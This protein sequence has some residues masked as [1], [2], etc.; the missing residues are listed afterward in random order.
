MTKTIRKNVFILM[1]AA[2]CLSGSVRAEITP[3]RHD[4]NVSQQRGKVTGTVTDNLGPVTGASVFV[5][6][7]TNGTVTDANGQF[8]LEGVQN[9]AIIQ[10]SFLG[11][12][13][14]EIPFTGQ[15]T[16]SVVLKEDTQILDEVVVV[17]YGSVK[18]AS[19]TGAVDQVKGSTLENRPIVSVGHALQGVVANLNITSS[20]SQNE[21]GGGA[22]GAKMNFNI[23]GTTGLNGDAASASA[24]P[25]IVIDG[26]Q[27]GDINSVNPD[28]IESISV[29]KDA[30][31]AAIYGSSAPYGVVLITTKQG[32]RERKPV[33]SYSNNFAMASVINLP[34]MM[35]SVDWAE[36]TNEA[37]INSI[38]TPFI[39]D[40]AMQRI[41]DYAAGKISTT[42]II[43]PAGN[44]VNQWAAYDP[45]FGN[46]NID[47]LR[48]YYKDYAFSQQHNASVSGGTEKTTYYVGLGYNHRGGMYNFGS[49]SFDRY[50]FRGNLSSSITKWL[51]ANFRSAFTRGYTD[52]PSSEHADSGGIMHDLARLWPIIP[53]KN[54]DGTVNRN[55]YID[56]YEN[57][58]RINNTDDRTVLTG[59]FVLNPLK[60]WNATFNYTFDHNSVLKEKN[61]LVPPNT[62]DA[63]GNTI[64]GQSREPNYDVLRRESGNY[65]HHTIN[66]FTSYELGLNDHYLKG[67]I[68]YT[69]EQRINRWFMA[70]SSTGHLYTPTV[71]TFPTIYDDTKSASEDRSTT[72]S[73]G[74]FGRINYGYKDKYLLEV[75]ARYDGTSRFLK[76]VRW[77]TY[78]GVSAAWVISKESFWEPVSDIANL[79]KLRFSYGSLGD[80]SFL[81]SSNF[82]YPLYY[83]PFSP[84]MGTTAPTGSNNNWIFGS[85]GRGSYITSPAIINEALTW[86]TST[87]FDIGVDLAA[88]DNRLSVTYDWF[89]RNSNDIVGPAEQLPAVLGSAAPKSNNAALE[90]NGFE[91]T[92][93]WRDQIGKVSYGIRGSLADS[94]TVVKKYPNEN[95]AISRWYAGDVVGNIW[96]FE[97]EGFFTAETAK[98][99]MEKK[100]QDAIHTIWSAG[101]IKYKDLDG[102]GKITTGSST[103]DDPGDRRIIGNDAARY[104]YGITL[105]AA[106]NGFDISLFFQGV[107]KRDAWISSNYFWGIT[108]HVWAHSLFEIHKDRWSEDNPNGYFP[109]FYFNNWTG[110]DQHTK[111]ERVQTKY[112]Q[113]A[114]YLRFKNM[115]IGYTIP[116]RILNKV[117]ISKL[118]VYVSG[119]NLATFTNM[120]KTVDPE[121]ATT[122]GK[123]YP[124]QRTWSLGLNL[125]F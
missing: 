90:T 97:T 59:E 73:R 104:T 98:E 52:T 28:D 95:K 19:L 102:D 18:K 14:Q 120:I 12:V 99:A 4:V 91:L 61:Y 72:A 7:T 1:A 113:D 17:G 21:G 112:L 60:G 116:S 89:R 119:E 77:K 96:G 27:G 25:L 23:R 48:M 92:V 94:K 32:R 62:K 33:V 47:W 37:M 41:R 9:D 106:W 8:T 44:E 87:T 101:D 53:Y 10:V 108:D 118:R 29:L 56:I 83:Y 51:T 80:L 85:G 121:F 71:P 86:V 79:L 36:M 107:G 50:S 125:T 105:D 13:T 54:P 82:S 26:I 6:G 67:M 76:D 15:S 122:S 109:K 81:N 65:T 115:Q 43:T 42:T 5:K 35:N 16:L 11:Y 24:S 66:A 68:G 34:K 58:G 20:T 111:N 63:L 78:P 38:G 46:D 30:A 100:T 124:L 123:I 75:N 49:D 64:P 114:S 45:Y 57:G 84:S 117:N 31:S 74:V 3:V 22:P 39:D 69:Q 40:A 70:E 2:L 110:N 88:F 55:N 103:V 93:A